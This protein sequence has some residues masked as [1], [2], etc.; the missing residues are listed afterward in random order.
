M[1]FSFFNWRADKIALAV[2]VLFYI[3]LGVYLA[4]FQESKIYFPD[5]RDFYSCKEFESAEKINFKGTRMYFKK[6]SEKIAIL[7]HGNAGSACDRY[8]YANI[9]EGKGYSYLIPEY[10]GFSNDSKKPSH[11]LIKKDVRNVLEFIALQNFSEAAVV[12]ESIGSGAASY[13]ASIK[14]PAKLLLISPFTSISEIAREIYWFYPISLMVNN[15]FVNVELL[16]NYKN[17]FMVIHGEND[18]IISY[19][20]GKKLFDAVASEGKKM[21]SISGA[22]HNDLPVHEI[23]YTSIYDFLKR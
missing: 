2:F 12:G 9:F 19:K 21:I 7:Y 8:F 11:N 6:V 16:K 13:H 17:T 15:A 5:N 23:F 14:S 20:F 4:I 22:S 1:K 10:A 18:E 3:F